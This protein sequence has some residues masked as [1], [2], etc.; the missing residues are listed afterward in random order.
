MHF[1]SVS[2][3]DGKP[4]LDDC[5]HCPRYWCPQACQQQSPDAD[6]DESHVQPALV[7]LQKFAAP[8][9]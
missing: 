9:D 2:M 4:D 7:R 1:R 3:S 5:Q 6:H 8:S